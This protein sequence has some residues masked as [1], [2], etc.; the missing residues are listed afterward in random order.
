M[1]LA[2]NDPEILVARCKPTNLSLSERSQY[3]TG[4]G[5]NDRTRSTANN[6]QSKDA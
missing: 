2:I 5:D 4:S 3:F 6:H 1:T